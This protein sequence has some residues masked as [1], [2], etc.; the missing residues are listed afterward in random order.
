MAVKSHNKDADVKVSI[1]VMK[2]LKALVYFARYRWRR[3][4]NI[5]PADWNAASLADIKVK[6]QQVQARKADKS[7]QTIDPGPIEVGTGYHDWVGRFRNK[8]KAT[9]GAADVPLIYIIRDEHEADWAPDPENAYEVELY[10]LRHT[11]PEYEED[12]KAVYAM[13]YNC[14]N[15]EKAGAD[16]L[17]EALVW[18][19]PYFDQQDGR[20]AFIAFKRH[21]EGE[22]PT[23]TR[24]TQAFASLKTLHW[25]SEA[26]MPFSKFASALK[27]AY[28]I[29]AKDANYGDEIKVRDLVDKLMPV[30]KVQSMEVV[31]RIV[32]R[33]YQNDFEGALVYVQGE[34]HDI[35]AE[36]IA[37]LNKYGGGVGKRGRQVYE[38]RVEGRGG[39]GRARHRNR[40]GRGQNTPRGGNNG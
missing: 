29:V 3:Q 33:E 21:F 6:M 31:K 7:A 28:D 38:T 23:N 39:R 11:G 12:N 32:S 18:I 17:R 24:K 10:S 16:T 1:V 30:S 20:T 22:G 2:N 27:K 40:Q 8:L 14:C 25:R 19:E 37:K 36:E 15:H 5:T 9:I 4:L 26:A 13:L 35:Y 34:I